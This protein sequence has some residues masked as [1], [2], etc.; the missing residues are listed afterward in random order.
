MVGRDIHCREPVVVHALGRATQALEFLFRDL[1]ARETRGPQRPEQFENV[2]VEAVVD[3]DRF[4][5][6]RAGNAVGAK[7]RGLDR[8]RFV[9]GWSNEAKIAALEDQAR[10][11][12]QRMHASG[13]KIAGLDRQR[14][15]FDDRVR[16]LVQFAVF[17][18]FR[19]LDW[20]PVAI[21]IDALER[22]RRQL[23]EESDVL[24]TLQGQ[25]YAL[26]TAID[27][28]GVDLNRVT[29]DQ[30]RRQERRDQA[31]D[32]L[33]EFTKQIS[34]ITDLVRL[35]LFPRL[36]AMRIEAERPLTVESCDSRKR[37][38][39]DRLQSQMDGEAKKI[40]RLRDKIVNAMT[41][42]T[43]DYP[44]ETREVDFSIEAA[45]DYRSMLA[46]NP[47]AFR[48]SR[49]ASRNCS[50][51]IRSARLRISNRN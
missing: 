30:A 14:A 47:M 10:G 1:S 28:T 16:L 35:Q 29:D 21:E 12:E 20:K 3:E 34:T 8:T 51:K 46:E 15:S 23:E 37:E 19:D 39:R 38:M 33:V 42:Y 40:E 5:L 45:A 25:L 48:G 44:M 13:D 6:D 36:N 41:A 43:Q 24:R 4:I 31:A 18:S 17:E 22:E 32:L 7:Q 11:L 27:Q 26:E 2:I 50:M 9:L 49:P